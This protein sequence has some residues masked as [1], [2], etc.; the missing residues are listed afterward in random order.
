MAQKKR[1]VAIDSSIVNPANGQ[2]L[3]LLHNN[4][5]EILT[6]YLTEHDEY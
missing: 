5:R 1:T 4:Q 3:L 6:I 2:R